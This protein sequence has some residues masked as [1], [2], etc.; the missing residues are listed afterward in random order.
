MPTIR[1]APSAPAKAPRQAIWASDRIATC[2]NGWACERLDRSAGVPGEASESQEES[3]MAGDAHDTIR[4]FWRIQ[5]EGDYSA[6]S[7]LFAEDAV[8]VDPVFGRFEGRE[9]IA[10]FM[11]KMNTEMKKV[12]AAFRLVE[13]AGDDETAWAQWRAETNAGP[14][15]GVGVLWERKGS[16]HVCI[17]R[18]HSRSWSRA[19]GARGAGDVRSQPR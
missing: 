6:L 17:L 11:T 8:L 4:E 7:D 5:D 2:A 15:D 12:G 9:A 16:R 14:R 1:M 10:A 3:R 13:L 18:G 19:M